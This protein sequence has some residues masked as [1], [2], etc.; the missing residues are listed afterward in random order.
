M[1]IT[2]FGWAILGCA[3]ISIICWIGFIGSIIHFVN[4]FW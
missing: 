1:K 4:K 3:V 2:P